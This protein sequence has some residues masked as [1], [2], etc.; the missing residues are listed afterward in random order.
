MTSSCV[1]TSYAN[2]KRPPRPRL[3]VLTPSPA[4]RSHEEADAQGPGG[5]EEA[6]VRRP[7]PG[8]RPARGRGNLRPRP[9]G[10]RRDGRE[11]RRRS[12]RTRAER[13]AAAGR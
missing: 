9:G 11:R 2:E 8:G 7:E 13:R 10:R 5:P 3:P 12:R 1:V 6:G 4:R